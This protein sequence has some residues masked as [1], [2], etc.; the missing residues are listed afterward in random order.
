MSLND[1]IISGKENTMKK[2]LS[3]IMALCMV[4]SVC[5]FSVAAEEVAVG[6][7][8]ADYK[9]AEGAIAITDAAGFAAMAADGNYYLANDI[10]VDATWNKTSDTY[11]ENTPFTGVLDGNGKTITASAPLFIYLNGTVKNLTIEG[12][13]TVEKLYGAAITMW[14]NAEFTV[15]NVYNKANVTGGSTS[16]AMLGYGASGCKA[17]FTGCRNDGVITGGGQTGGIA[18]YI[19][20]TE[21]TITDCVNNGDINPSSYGAGIIG[22]FGKDKSDNT[23][24]IT[25]KNC[26]NNGKVTSGGD[27]NSGILGYAIGTI[28]IDNCVNNGDIT[29]TGKN[30]GGILGHLSSYKNDDK[31]Y[32]RYSSSLITNCVNNGTI[33]GV[34]AV[35]GIAGRNGNNHDSF[36]GS[37]GYKVVNCINN[38]DV[39]VNAGSG[40][41]NAAGI[42]GYGWGGD[43][44]NGNGIYNCVNNGD[45]TI[46]G[47]TGTIYV[48]GIMG[49]VNCTTYIVENCI[50]AGAVSSEVAPKTAA[51]IVYNKSANAVGISN[52][53]SVASGN[54]PVC[55]KG[56]PAELYEGVSTVATAEQIANG[57][58]A[59]L[60]NEA[61][62]KTVYYQAIGTDKAPVLTAA[63]DGSN[64]IVKNADGTFGNPAPEAE[65]TEPA[66]ETTEPAPETTEPAPE[67][68]EPGSSTPTG[69]SA[70]IFAVIAV[71]S[72]LGVA[73]V[74]KKREN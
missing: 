4:L 21:V 16:G 15:E 3:I 24:T 14:S 12:T 38:G 63:E 73:V 54:I 71:I 11:K 61:V 69:D 66:P 47:G 52:C 18:G 62:G 58:V 23:Y 13:I 39:I 51:L 68:T 26:V 6:S 42:V 9:P 20:G 2:T 25:I 43:G 55:L 60:I 64:A 28:V 48:G 40:S 59:G 8:A 53:Y 27:Q 31:T 34:T 19:Q 35:G 37:N 46:K 32:R 33:T 45:V 65:T 29:T 56:D 5:F 10:T 44:T 22:R 17:T 7:V 50:N 41:V 74:A 1:N 57:T 72:V 36:E 67:T 49:Y 30:A 70:L